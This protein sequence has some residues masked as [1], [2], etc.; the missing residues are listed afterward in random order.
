M[1]APRGGRSSSS[2]NSS[3]SCPIEM[4]CRSAVAA[5]QHVT[6]RCQRALKWRLSLGLRPRGQSGFAFR[7]DAMAALGVHQHI[8][9][10]LD[11]LILAPSFE[12][13]VS[14]SS[15]A[16]PLLPPR[17][18]PPTP[19]LPTPPPPQCRELHPSLEPDRVQDT[20][21]AR[22]HGGSRGGAAVHPSG[23]AQ[24]VSGGGGGWEVEW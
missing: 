22:G 16:P 8:A 21:A 17:P 11:S 6:A 3:G 15:P 14:V 24:Q 13:P 12:F 18:P 19:I 2:A 4:G 20:G 1:S 9:C 23:A 10:E 7:E 5:A